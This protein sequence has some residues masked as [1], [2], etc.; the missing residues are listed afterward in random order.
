MTVATFPRETVSLPS[1]VEVE[2]SLLGAVLLDNRT[3][4]VAVRTVTAADFFGESNGLIFRAMQSLAARNDGIDVTTLCAELDRVDTLDRAGG[5]SY[6]SSLID[7]MPTGGNIEQYARLVKD[8]ASRRALIR[9]AD[10]VA[11]EA[12]EGDTETCEIIERGQQAFAE[13]A[14]ANSSA[15]A[16]YKV[17]T[18]ADFLQQRFP[19]RRPLLGPIHEKDLWMVHAYRGTGKTFFILG[20]GIAAATGMPLFSRWAAATPA[21]VLVIDGEMPAATLQL[22]ISKLLAGLDLSIGIEDVPLRILAADVQELPLPPL[23]TPAGRRVLDA[24][25]GDAKLVILD[26]ISTLFVGAENEGDDWGP[27]QDLLLSLRRRGVTVILVHHSGKT[28]LQRGTSRRE[29]VLDG[30][31]KLEHPKGYQADDGARFEVKF[32]KA[33]GLVGKDVEPF[34]VQLIQDADGAATWTTR[35][36]GGRNHDKS[37]DLLRTGMPADKVASELGIDRSTVYRHRLKAIDGGL[38]DA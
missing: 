34:E 26:N 28:G 23:N 11:R 30:V 16:R 7:G 12:M 2:R 17:H 5:A 13:V 36:I 32:E 24:H 20:I 37:I 21:P 33:R 19:P 8:S 6:M 4:A 25:I 10:K 9:V 22:R 29:D 35:S 38:L 18:L 31:I 15:A 3:L 1:A 27:T 14:Q